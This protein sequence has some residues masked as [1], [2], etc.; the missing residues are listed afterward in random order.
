M[1]YNKIENGIRH[2]ALGRNTYNG[3]FTLGRGIVLLLYSIIQTC[4]QIIHPELT[5]SITLRVYRKNGDISQEEIHSMLLGKLK[6][7]IVKTI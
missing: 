3:P 2:G 1:E 4:K 7:I 6:N 5:C